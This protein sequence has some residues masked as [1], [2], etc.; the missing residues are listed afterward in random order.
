M[1]A[2]LSEK[3]LRLRSSIKKQIESHNSDLG[4]N[5]DQRVEEDELYRKIKDVDLDEDLAYQ[6]SCWKQIEQMCLSKQSLERMMDNIDHAD[7][8]GLINF[9]PDIEY[10]PVPDNLNELN[11]SKFG[12]LSSNSKELLSHRKNRLL[13]LRDEAKAVHDFYFSKGE[14]SLEILEKIESVELFLNK[15]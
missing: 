15:K 14:L 1:S 6:V 4:T 12:A 9:E 8:F 3:A 10:K 2:E 11:V 13:Q 5:E 7:E